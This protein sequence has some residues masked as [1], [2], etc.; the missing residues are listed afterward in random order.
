VQTIVLRRFSLQKIIINL[1]MYFNYFSSSYQNVRLR[2]ELVK[3]K[4]M[5]ADK[6]HFIQSALVMVEVF[7]LLFL[8]NTVASACGL[9]CHGKVL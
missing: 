2:K 1:H 7:N 5:L 6:D 3:L 9:Y 8:C 4:K